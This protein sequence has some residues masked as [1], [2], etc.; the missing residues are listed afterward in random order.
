MSEEPGVSARFESEEPPGGE[1]LKA[2]ER[3]GAAG[4]VIQEV[5]R[6]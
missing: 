1:R 5:C 4:I 6:T 2:F 3:G